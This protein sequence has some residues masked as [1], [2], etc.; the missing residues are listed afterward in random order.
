[1]TTPDAAQGTATVTITNGTRTSAGTGPGYAVL[2]WAEAKALT[3]AGLAL[4][5]SAPPPNM[6]AAPV[7]VSPA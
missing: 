3:D 2:P 1:M 5:G 6:Q 4:W 7:P